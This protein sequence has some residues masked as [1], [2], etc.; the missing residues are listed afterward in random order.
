M[1]RKPYEWSVL[2]DGDTVLTWFTEDMLLP[3][4]V[5]VLEGLCHHNEHRVQCIGDKGV[6][7]TLHDY[8]GDDVRVTIERV[9]REW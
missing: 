2:L 7:S 3:V 8:E 1:G 5:V 6:F 9:R 4:E